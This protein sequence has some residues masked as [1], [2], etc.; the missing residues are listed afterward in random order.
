MKINRYKREISA[1]A[2]FL[3]LLAVVGTI[4]PPFFDGGN[5]RDLVIN[6]APTLL[7]ATGMTLVILVGEIDISVGS[8]FAVCSIVAGFLAKTGV[9]LPV[10]LLS[11]VAIGALM[12]ALNG[13]L[14]GWLRL[15]SIIVTLAML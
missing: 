5:L 6:N 9:P 11:V 15:P 13:A 12:G 4:T 7:I 10:L 3:A 14:V 8:Q 1:A 2:T